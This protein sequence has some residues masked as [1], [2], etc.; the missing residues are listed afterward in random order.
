MSL[1]KCFLHQMY[2]IL[3]TLGKIIDLYKLWQK[4]KNIMEAIKLIEE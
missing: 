1:V 3:T 4:L 2:C